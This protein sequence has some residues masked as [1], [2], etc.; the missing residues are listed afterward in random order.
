MPTNI[1]TKILLLVSVTLLAVIVGLVAGILARV[2]GAT[3]AASVR[4]AGIGFGASLTL[5]LAI[6]TAYTLL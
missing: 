6:T 3:A 4:A 1:I 2:D 5:F